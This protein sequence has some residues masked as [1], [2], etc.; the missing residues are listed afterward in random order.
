[1]P[2]ITPRSSKTQ[3]SADVEL[4][5]PFSQNQRVHVLLQRTTIKQPP[6][7]VFLS[8]GQAGLRA[9]PLPAK[10]PLWQQSSILQIQYLD[11]RLSVQVPCGLAGIHEDEDR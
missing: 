1:M 10:E 4:M 11:Q 8:S 2:P 9:G 3:S 7:F 6:T 5:V